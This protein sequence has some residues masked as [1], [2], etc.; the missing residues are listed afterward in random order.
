MDHDVILQIKV[1]KFSLFANLIENLPC[2]VL[3]QSYTIV[4]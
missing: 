1:S 2:E 4:S 3:L